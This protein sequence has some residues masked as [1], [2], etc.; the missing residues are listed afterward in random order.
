MSGGACE[1]FVEAVYDL[2]TYV[3]KG[4]LRKSTVP[5]RLRMWRPYL[6]REGTYRSFAALSTFFYPDVK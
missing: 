4:S 2:L 6:V 1:G 5:Y 3:K